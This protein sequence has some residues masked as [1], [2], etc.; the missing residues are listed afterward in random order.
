MGARQAVKVGPKTYTFPCSGHGPKHLGSYC[1]ASKLGYLFGFCHIDT[2][3][4]PRRSILAIFGPTMSATPQCGVKI[5]P[6]LAPSKQFLKPDDARKGYREP[7]M[8][9]KPP[10]KSQ[11]PQ[12]YEGQG[13]EGTHVL[14]KSCC[15]RA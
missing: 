9:T 8:S 10:P 2:Q 6:N 5:E 1:H 14:S 4:H 3:K 15:E 12:N 11:V 13:Q 7:T